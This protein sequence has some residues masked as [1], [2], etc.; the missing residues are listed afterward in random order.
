MTMVFD[1]RAALAGKPGL[2]AFIAGAG[3]YR[4]LPGF[5]PAPG[6]T[7]TPAP[8]NYNMGQLP[9]T[10]LTVARIVEWLIRNNTALTFPL[11]TCRVLVSD[12]HGA[13]PPAFAPAGTTID[14]CSRDNFDREAKSWRD[15][16]KGNPADATLFYFAG[17]GIQRSKDDSVMLMDDFGDGSG[18]TLNKA[19][20]S[21]N[22][23]NGMGDLV[24]YP[25]IAKTQLFFIDACRA[26]PS[27]F[28]QYEM[29]NVP[30]LWD[31]PTQAL[32][33]RT[34][35][36]YH[37]TRSGQ[38]AG[39]IPTVGTIFGEA[40]ESCLDNDAAELD[41]T[42][43]VASWQITPS[44][45]TRAMRIV[46]AALNATYNWDQDFVVDRDSA[47]ATLR[48]FANPPRVRV[49]LE[50]DP[51]AAAR[52]SVL[53]LTDPNGTP[54]PVSIPIPLG[55]SPFTIPSH[56]VGGYYRVGVKIVPATPPLKNFPVHTF[57]VRPPAVNWKLRVR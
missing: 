27:E 36:I 31:V 57:T 4:H 29:M 38:L 1:N 16:A 19:V 2:H 12:A 55:R 22:L 3:A 50:L 25:N 23:Y 5:V 20:S 18:G 8:K 49:S 46:V 17:H 26:M 28:T 34:A 42:T 47:V 52:Y 40:L 41:D 37:A 39:G 10:P 30:N 45:L 33:P 54:P 9:S 21:G 13:S 15:D 44:S 24:G 6:V 53:I 43:G 32:D 35:P 11:A 48:A 7:F 14:R 56:L 51:A